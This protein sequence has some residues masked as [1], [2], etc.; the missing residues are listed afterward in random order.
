L[1]WKQIIF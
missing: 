1:S